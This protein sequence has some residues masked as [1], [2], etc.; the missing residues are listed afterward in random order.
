MYTKLFFSKKF[1]KN[2]MLIIVIIT[3][4][5]TFIHIN[6]LK[7]LNHLFDK[8]IPIINT[9]TILYLTLYNKV[10]FVNIS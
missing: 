8:L 6:Y 9:N 7:S 5:N 4:I 3:I 1:N 2:K 10:S